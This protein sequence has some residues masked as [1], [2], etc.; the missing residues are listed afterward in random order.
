MRAIVLTLLGLAILAGAAPAADARGRLNHAAA[1]IGGTT[2]LAA[3]EPE[4]GPSSPGPTN[5]NGPSS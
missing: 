1:P 3:L 4:T 5:P 2:Q